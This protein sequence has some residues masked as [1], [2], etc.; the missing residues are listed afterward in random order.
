MIIQLVDAFQL[1]LENFDPFKFGLLGQ[2]LVH[3]SYGFDA[4]SNPY[5]A[6][7]LD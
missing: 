6:V 5:T 7:S 2:R 4:E 1:L 3:N